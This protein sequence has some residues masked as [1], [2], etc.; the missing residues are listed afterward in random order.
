MPQLQQQQTSDQAQA[1]D[2]QIQGPELAVE[3]QQGNAAALEAAEIAPQ[4]KPNDGKLRQAHGDHTRLREEALVAQEKLAGGIEAISAML[5]KGGTV[6]TPLCDPKKIKG[7]ERSNDKVDFKYG[8]DASR[9]TD[10][11]RGSIVFKD[12][13]EVRESFPA[14]VEELEKRGW[15]LVGN[16]KDRFLDPASGYRD[17]LMNVDIDGHIC[18]LQL[19]VEKMMEAKHDSAGHDNY[20]VI[21]DIEL[22]QMKTGVLDAKTTETL[23]GATADMVGHYEGKWDEHEEEM[24]RDPE[25]FARLE[26]LRANAKGQS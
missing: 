17:M 7:I 13:L 4:E 5:A 3:Q 22:E 19:H 15:N 21:R 2:V 14:V 16:V 6:T 9:L 24:K 11:A 1:V 23:Q 18:E 12:E 25:R 8:G 20:K 26:E 10:I